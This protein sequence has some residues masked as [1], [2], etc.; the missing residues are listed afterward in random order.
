MG[1]VA[2]WRI[3]YACLGAL[4]LNME[5]DRSA[6]GLDD[7]LL[8]AVMNLCIGLS[9]LLVPLFTKSLISDGLTQA[10]TTLATGTTLAVGG[11]AKAV[12]STFRRTVKRQPRH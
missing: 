3:V 1:M 11:L 6:T 12:A 7:W 5:L 8:S 9:M 2:S 10:G 4:L